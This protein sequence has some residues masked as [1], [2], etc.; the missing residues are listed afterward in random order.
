MIRIAKL[1]DCGLTLEQY[2]PNFP[3]WQL[4][5]CVPVL[6]GHQLSGGSGASDNLSTFSNAQFN[7]VYKRTERNIT[8]RKGIARFNVG[9]RS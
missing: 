4:D 9:L 6:F 8:Q 1:T 7:V 3:G 2:H 5:K